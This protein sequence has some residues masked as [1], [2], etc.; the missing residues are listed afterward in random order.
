MCDP[1]F[2]DSLHEPFVPY[3][4]WRESQWCNFNLYAELVHLFPNRLE[5]C[6]SNTLAVGCVR[7]LHR[8]SRHAQFRREDLHRYL[9]LDSHA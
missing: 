3:T 2:P 4:R 7:H 9:H 8:L 1:R 5:P 6:G